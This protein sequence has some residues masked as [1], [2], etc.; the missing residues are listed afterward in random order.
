MNFAPDLSSETGLFVVVESH[1]GRHRMVAQDLADSLPA[2][3]V[4]WFP[5]PADYSDNLLPVHLESILHTLRVT[6]RPV[7]HAGG[8]V[9]MERYYYRTAIATAILPM[10]DRLRRMQGALTETD[11]ERKRRLIGFEQVSRVTA[12]DSIFRRLCPEPDLVLYLTG[13]TGEIGELYRAL[14]GNGPRVVHEIGSSGSR[15]AIIGEAYEMVHA[16]R[17]AKKARL[18][19]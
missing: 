18:I 15:D 19:A 8:L 3:Y 4:P 13:A 16:A 10:C 12:L 9:V 6:V 14:L 5:Q 7:L 1:E 2:V 17:M 11:L